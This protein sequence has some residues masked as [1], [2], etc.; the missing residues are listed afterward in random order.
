M[1][2]RFDVAGVGLNATDTLLVVPRFP[3]YAGK[4]PF[5]EEFL[6]PGGQVAVA[7]QNARLA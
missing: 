5:E 1:P 2:P 7:R 6:S 4:D 3:P